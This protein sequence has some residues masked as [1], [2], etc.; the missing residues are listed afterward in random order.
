MND[1]K[2]GPDYDLAPPTMSKPFEWLVKKPKR[3]ILKQVAEIDRE[4]TRSEQAVRVKGAKAVLVNY[5]LIQHDFP[6]LRK[7]ALTTQF[8]GLKNLPAMDQEAEIRRIIDTWLVENTAFVSTAQAAQT[9]VNTEIP[10]G[11]EKTLAFRPPDYG[12]AMVFSLE[13][14]AR[15]LGQ[16]PPG[17]GLLD[18]KGVGVAP[19]KTPS[20]DDH[21]NGLFE[22]GSAF[23]EI[24]MQQIIE[25]AFRHAGGM[26]D[27]LPNYG[28]IDLGFDIIDGDGG[29][30]HAG[31]LVRRAHVR[32]WS[33]GA[34]PAGPLEEKYMMEIELLLRKYGITS[35]CAGTT[36]TLWES[37]GQLYFVNK[38]RRE[39][40]QFTADAEQFIR[41]KFPIAEKPVS[42]QGTNVQLTRNLDKNPPKTTLVDFT[43]YE[44]IDQCCSAV[45]VS[46][47]NGHLFLG[48]TILH[49]D[50]VGFVHPDPQ[51]AIPF[52]AS[53][54]VGC[55]WGYPNPLRKSKFMRLCFQIAEDYRAGNIS[56]IDV[57]LKLGA[58]LQQLTQHL[59]V[60]GAPNKNSP[61][62]VSS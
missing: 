12:R 3:P 40:G 24:L 33:A 36:Y 16:T 8:P 29:Q 39:I 9:V 56:R 38:F 58:Y 5:G 46:M 43:H 37:G 57:S 30:R 20:A 22:L 13:E 15:A 7:T 45:Y 44:I 61:T 4:E 26:F 55:I 18:V 51:L 32:Q 27:T 21:S 42:I 54:E 11:E 23:A 59:Y 49:P 10:L 50:D 35:T 2:S 19:D 60:P 41:R 25:R 31:L 47:H 1:I 52:R 34:F 62:E 17:S 14:N 28:A 6:F 53:G 48:D